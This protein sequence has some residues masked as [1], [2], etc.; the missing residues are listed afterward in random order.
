MRWQVRAEVTAYESSHDYCEAIHEI[1]FQ[2]PGNKSVVS[3]VLTAHYVQ[4]VLAW[5]TKQS[6]LDNGQKNP[7]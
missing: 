6:F 5:H 4:S 1:L 3:L 2:F 7:A